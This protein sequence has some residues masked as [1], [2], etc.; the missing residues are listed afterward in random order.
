MLVTSISASAGFMLSWKLSH[1][2]GNVTRLV[3]CTEEGRKHWKDDGI[4]PTHMAPSWTVH[5]RTG[6]VYRLFTSCGAAAI[7]LS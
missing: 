1:Q 4:M 3:S 7:A 2:L 6:D 5:P